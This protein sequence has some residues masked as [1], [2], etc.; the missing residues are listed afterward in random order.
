M[1]KNIKNQTEI[2]NYFFGLYN[3]DC[4]SNSRQVRIINIAM[5]NIEQ[6]E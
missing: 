4:F 1:T 2:T 5:N 3:N 6:R